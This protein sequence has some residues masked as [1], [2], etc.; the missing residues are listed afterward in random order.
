MDVLDLSPIKK[1]FDV[2]IS[3]R[4]IINLPTRELQKKAIKEIWLSLKRGGYYIMVE[5]FIEGHNVMNKLRKRLG[6]KEISVRW[7]NN[8]LDE[9]FLNS[10]ISRY[11]KIS[12]RKNIS[13]I[14][15]LITRTVYSKICQIENREP[16]YDNIIYKIAVGLDEA[17]GNYGP[18]NL[19]LLKKRQY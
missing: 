1:K 12:T 14:Y 10:F 5:N 9:K 18:I 4:C 13:S 8:Y 15:Y 2:I 6:L 16:D 3:D 11:F 17:E 19:L 7:H